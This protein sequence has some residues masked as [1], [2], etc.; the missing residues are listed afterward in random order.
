VQRDVTQEVK[1]EQQLRQSQKMESIGTLAGGI[2]HDFN[3]ILAII[4]GYSELSLG[5]AKDNPEISRPLQHILDATHRARDLVG[6]ILTFSRATA[7]NKS[8]IKITPIVKEVCK[9]LRSSLPTTIEIKQEITA[10][11]DWIMA[12]PT[13]FHQIL[14]NL[15][16]NAG[17]SMRE[18]GGNLEVLLENVDLNEENISSYSGLKPGSYL[19]LTVKDTDY[20]ISSE[21]L[22]RIFEP[23]FTTKE[24]GEGTGLGL[25]VVHGI[26]KESGGEI[27]AYSE[28][29]QGTVFHVLFPLIK[30]IEEVSSSESF[31]PLPTG[32]ETIMFVD[33]EELLV[34]VGTEILVQLGYRVNKTNSQQYVPNL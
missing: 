32:T 10:E 21:N 7:V 34:K 26:V 23:Y 4:L 27:K 15:C 5:E 11:N 8:S 22:E 3:N 9:F 28:E 17:H 33:D 14:M 16:T 25:A 1:M 31:E 29:G 12:D 30:E 24:L 18:T 2:A 13:Q 6:Q 20:G 19:K